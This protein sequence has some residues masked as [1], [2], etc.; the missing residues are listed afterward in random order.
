MGRGWMQIHMAVKETGFIY[1]GLHIQNIC[2]NHQLIELA[3]INWAFNSRGIYALVV[4]DFWCSWKKAHGDAVRQKFWKKTL[5]KIL[6]FGRGS[7]FFL[8]RLRGTNS[9][10]TTHLLTLI[11]FNRDKDDCFK[12]LLLIKSYFFFHLNTLNALAVDLQGWMP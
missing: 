8:T 9:N 7:D 10:K 6:F 4:F 5:A 3:F 12:Y 1:S 2:S 11:I